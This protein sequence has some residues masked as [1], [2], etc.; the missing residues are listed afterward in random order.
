MGELER[1]LRFC[2][3]ETG[4]FTILRLS[5]RLRLVET[6]PSQGKV[7]NPASERPPLSSHCGAAPSLRLGRGGLRPLPTISL[8][9][10]MGFL[11][12]TPQHCVQGGDRTRAQFAAS[13]HQMFP[14]DALGLLVQ[15][16]TAPPPPPLRLPG[17]LRSRTRSAWERLGA[18][19]SAQPPHA[20]IRPPP[21]S[22][23]K[24]HC[25]RSCCSE[26]ETEAQPEWNVLLHS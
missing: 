23:W 18:P 6:H 3:V 5:E 26:G 16:L 9:C 8:I 12:A 11:P 21:A 15:S 14:R 2:K 1:G 20:L 10:R 24:R 13:V 19:G 7:R 17:L 22:L 4:V 25:S